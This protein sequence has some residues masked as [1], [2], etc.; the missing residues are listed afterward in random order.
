MYLLHYLVESVPAE[1]LYGR[2]CSYLPCYYVVTQEL[3]L[4]EAPLSHIWFK[5]VILTT[6]LT[7]KEEADGLTKIIWESLTLPYMPLAALK[8]TCTFTKFVK[9]SQKHL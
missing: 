9:C 1:L 8:T 3:K 7:S 6:E 2:R 5:K 4:D